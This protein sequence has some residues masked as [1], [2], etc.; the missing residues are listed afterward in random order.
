[1]NDTQ[2]LLIALLGAIL[3]VII[4]QVVTRKKRK[5][6]KEEYPGLW[7]QFELSKERNDR[8]ELVKMGNKLFYHNFLPTEHLKIIHDTAEELES[9]LPEF[10]DLL[11]NAKK[12]LKHREREEGFR[13]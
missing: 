10:K 7:Q 3:L 5:R 6:E 11:S 1:M 2:I 13:G 12:K 8:E 4:L 9:T